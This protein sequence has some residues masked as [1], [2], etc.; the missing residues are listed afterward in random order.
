MLQKQL[1]DIRLTAKQLTRESAKC[2]KREAAQKLKLKAAIQKGDMESAKIFAQNAI[3]EKQQ[4][5]SLLRLS[6]R[7]DAVSQRVDRA[8]TMGQLTKSMKGVVHG[9]DKALASMDAAQISKV[10]DKFVSNFEELDFQTEV[11]SGEIDRS[12]GAAMREEDVA[13]MIQ[14]VADEH[15]LMVN[16]ALGSVPVAPPVAKVPAQAAATAEE[17]DLEAR[18]AALKR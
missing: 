10:M 8:L 15:G 5:L 3:R 14:M 1:F 9:M 6:S 2:E 11:V 16:E 18:L 13:N 7:M 12:T 4:A 17:D